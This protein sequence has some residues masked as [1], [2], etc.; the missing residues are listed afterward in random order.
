MVAEG[1]LIAPKFLSEVKELLAAHP[2]TEKTGL[3]LL[4]DEGLLCRSSQL[5]RW[6]R[7]DIEAGCPNVEPNVMSVTKALQIV[8]VCLIM[9][10]LHPDV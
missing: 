1:N 2:G 6:R 5:N 10:V 9:D 3:L 4:A 8:C 7:E